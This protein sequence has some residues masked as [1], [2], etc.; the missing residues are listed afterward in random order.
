MNSFEPFKLCP[1]CSAAWNTRDEFLSDASVELIGYQVH[2]ADLKLGYFMFVHDVCGTTIALV[3]DKF[4]DLYQGEPFTKRLTGSAECPAFCLH[5]EE[6][7]PCRN[8][9][10][11]A[12][13][14]DIIQTIRNWPGKS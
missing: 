8:K 12:Y 7:D 13:V 1:H 3:A 11:C 9:C 10:E 14:R 2:F 4:S 5:A 6:L